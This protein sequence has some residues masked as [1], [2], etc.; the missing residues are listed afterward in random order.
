MDHS[1]RVG[2]TQA[3]TNLQDDLDDLARLVSTV[4]EMLVQVLA[5]DM[6]HDE[7]VQPVGHAEIV[8]R[9]DVRMMQASHRLR[10]LLEL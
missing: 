10:L 4:V 2:V 5:I 7:V 6:L 3:V 9:H 1:R 8:H